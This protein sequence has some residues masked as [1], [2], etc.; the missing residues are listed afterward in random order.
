[1]KIK[2]NLILLSGLVISLNA[3]S[4]TGKII[5]AETSL[6]IPYV[7]IYSVSTS[8]GTITNEVGEFEWN[9]SASDSVVITHLSYEPQKL[10]LSQ[11]SQVIKLKPHAAL[12]SEVIVSD[13]GRSLMTKTFQMALKNMDAKNFGKAF[14][15]QITRNNG[16]PTEVQEIFYTIES[17]NSGVLRN[18]I[19]EARYAFKQKKDSAIHVHMSN[20]AAFMLSAGTFSTVLVE[21]KP[22]LVPLMPDAD[23]FYTFS[24]VEKY[25]LDGERLVKISF[26]PNEDVKKPAAYGEVIINESSLAIRNLSIS[27][28]HHLGMDTIKGAKGKWPT[29]NNQ[30]QLTFDF[31][32]NGQLNYIKYNCG[33][34]FDTKVKQHKVEVEAFLFVYEQLNKTKDKLHE[35]EL[36]SNDIALIRKKKYNAKFWKDNPIV[37]RTPLQEDI[38]NQFEKDG[39][40]GTM[41]SKK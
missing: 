30:H 13:F 40:F 24:L 35:T 8:R 26:E 12:L 28:K 16:V 36:K 17:N 3:L 10:L 23:S 20:A 37:K 22:L 32:R 15:R 6:P 11:I 38:T 21:K 4:Q 29:F 2:A 19:N 27:V 5:D 41:F 18:S 31:L 34:E 14:Y 33:F 9:A 7:N 39:N 1:M 25:D